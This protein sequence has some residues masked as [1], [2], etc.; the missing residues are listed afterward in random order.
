MNNSHNGQDSVVKFSDNLRDRH[1]T[2][3]ND[4]SSDNSG[5]AVDEHTNYHAI[6]SRYRSGNLTSSESSDDQ[7]CV[8]VS[9]VSDPLDQKT[10]SKSLTRSESDV[11]AGS[12]KAKNNS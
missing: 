7:M 5:L 11:S 3:S 6:N 10:S 2:G 4:N 1:D 8:G 12:P 9:R